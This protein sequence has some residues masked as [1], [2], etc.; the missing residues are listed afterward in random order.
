MD[1]GAPNMCKSLEIPAEGIG[2][3][4]IGVTSSCIRSY[5]CV[6]G[7]EPGSVVRAMHFL[8]RWALSLVLI[9]WNFSNQDRVWRGRVLKKCSGVRTQPLWTYWWRFVLLSP[10]RI[11]SLPLPC[12]YFVGSFLK[13]CDR[14]PSI[15]QKA[16]KYWN[17]NL[18][19]PNTCNHI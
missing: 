6:L 7:T 14:P 3:P 18:R 9:C 11:C 2:S 1:V 13:C 8:N 5:L 19:L 16:N 12:I 15:P 10:K 4:R 17:H